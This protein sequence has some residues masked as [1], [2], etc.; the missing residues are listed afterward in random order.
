MFRLATMNLK[1]NGH[2]RDWEFI[3]Y[4]EDVNFWMENL[5]HFVTDEPFW[6]FNSKQKFSKGGWI[7]NQRKF[8]VIEI[9]L[10]NSKSR[11]AHPLS[12]CKTFSFVFLF[13]FKEKL[14]LFE[15]SIISKR[16][17]YSYLY[18]ICFSVIYE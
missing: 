4:K 11:I 16:K 2:K 1:R 17:I 9:F 18:C 14:F 10:R 13:P 12:K 3:I 7:E 6:Y 15:M 8:L 5:F